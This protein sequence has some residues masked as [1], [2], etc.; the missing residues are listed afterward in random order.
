MTFILQDCIGSASM[1]NL[2][3]TSVQFPVPVETGAYIVF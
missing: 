1:S 3:N 2:W